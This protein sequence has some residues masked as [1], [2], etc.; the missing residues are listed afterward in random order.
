MQVKKSFPEE[1]QA[2]LTIVA[3]QSDL[4]PIKQHVLRHLQGRVKVAG[5]REGNVPLALVEKN[6]SPDTLQTEFLEEAINHLY[7]SVAKELRLRP[8]SQPQVSVKKFV[9]F[10]ELEFDVDVEII[11]A[12]T[13][14]DY[15]KIKRTKETAKVEA[16]DI[17]DVLKNLQTRAAEK[18]DVE[19]ASRDGDE[20]WIDFTGT[21]AKG[22]PV[23]G[24]DGKDYPL[25]LGSNTFIPGFEPNLVGLKADE[26]KTFPLKFPADYG[27]KAIAGKNVTFSVTVKKVQEVVL[28]KLDDDFVAKIGPFK[29]LSELKADIRKQLTLERQ[30]ELDRQYENDLVRDITA[31]SKAAVPKRLVDEQV[32]QME[33]EERRNLTYRGQ[34][35][36]EHLK[37][38]KVTAEEHRE[39][40]RP[41]AEERVRAGLVL[42][43]IAEAEGLEVTPEEVEVRVQLLKNQYQD[44]AMQGELDKPENRRDIASRILTEKTLQ[45]LT[46]FATKS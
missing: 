32:D 43:E 22:E 30:N 25:L 6:V 42:S 5:F 17:N 4:E 44:N 40:K 14:P 11:G 35:W 33:E 24:A 27:V 23:N 37:E 8:V 39:Q 3:Q 20:V 41:Q 28:P 9:P 1:T 36:E 19:R 12:I 10:T 18:K 34:T 13:L 38:E 46:D 21:D 31:K 26:Q 45:K 2:Q 7:M 16:I 29:S 15:K